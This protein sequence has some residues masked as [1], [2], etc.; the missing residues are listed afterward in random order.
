MNK[1]KIILFFIL[2]FHCQS[3]F[4]I[5]L[6]MQYAGNIGMFSLGVGGSFFNEKL[7]IFS[8]FGQINN[9]LTDVNEQIICGGININSPKLNLYNSINL[10]PIFIGISINYH[11]GDDYFIT[12]PNKYPDSYYKQTALNTAYSL[13][14]KIQW[15]NDFMK[16]IEISEFYFQVGTLNSYLKSYLRSKFE[17]GFIELYDIINLSFGFTVYF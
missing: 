10:I 1:F 12:L 13:G 3:V 14:F 11:L 17:E 8:M 16:I 5:H 4:G 7:N 2:L 9:S 15:K 6:K